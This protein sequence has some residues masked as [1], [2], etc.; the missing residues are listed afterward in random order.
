MMSARPPV[1]MA[2]GGNAE[3]EEEKDWSLVCYESALEATL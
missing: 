2:S 1:Y 3:E